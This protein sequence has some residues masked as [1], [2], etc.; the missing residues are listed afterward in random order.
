MLSEVSVKNIPSNEL[1]EFIKTLELDLNDSKKTACEDFMELTLKNMAVFSVHNFCYTRALD[2]LK[3]S[4]T[5]TFSV[6][7]ALHEI[8]N[9][10]IRDYF[11]RLALTR[12]NPQAR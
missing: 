1:R 7:K 2:V 8:L 4:D 6:F 3:E 9:G 10:Y 12:N 11:R 5:R